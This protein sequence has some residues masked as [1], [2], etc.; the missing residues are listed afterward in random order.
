MLPQLAY[1]DQPDTP[2]GLFL[3]AGILGTLSAEETQE[4]HAAVAHAVAEG[5]YL[6]A[7]AHHGAV[8]IK[9]KAMR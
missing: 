7:Q 9:P 6:I 5:T 8:G 2:I 3:Q 1:Y 4:W